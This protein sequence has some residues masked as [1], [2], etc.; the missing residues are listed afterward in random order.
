MEN[1]PRENL[2]EIDISN[3]NGSLFFD[4]ENAQT[5][6]EKFIVFFLDDELFAV[7][8]RKV[9]EVVHP[10][11]I[12]PLPN[13]PEW[14][15]GIANLR[16]EI[17]S[18]VDLAKLWRK[19]IFGTALKPKLIVLRGQNSNSS[20]A[21]TADRLSEII[22]LS[23]DKI[24]FCEEETSHIFGKSFHKSNVLNFVDTDKLALSLTLPA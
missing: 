22:T 12:T 24:H 10:P 7:S 9:A 5:A 20:I 14:L 3:L 1:N 21:F 19:K 13:V 6:G 18:V 23:E 2:S 4:K 17:I 8:A 11:A 15:T 16:G